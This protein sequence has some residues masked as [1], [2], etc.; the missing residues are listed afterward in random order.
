MDNL[1][2]HLANDYI[3]TASLNLYDTFTLI[4]VEYAKKKQIKQRNTVYARYICNALKVKFKKE[5]TV[6]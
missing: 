6:S 3:P 5:I 2:C 4:F 1:S